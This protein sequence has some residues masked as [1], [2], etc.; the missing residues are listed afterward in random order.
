MDQESPTQIKS[1]GSGIYGQTFLGKIT[2]QNTE[3]DCTIKVPTTAEGAQEALEREALVLTKISRREANY[4]LIRLIKVFRDPNKKIKSV[5]TEFIPGDD[6]TFWSGFSFTELD[7]IL[8]DLLV[9]LT[10]IHSMDV[11][12]RDIKPAN[13]MYNQKEAVL[14]DFGSSSFGTV[15]SKSLKGSLRFL[16]KEL[17]YLADT[18]GI[19]PLHVLKRADVFALGFTVYMMAH[20]NKHPFEL[21]PGEGPQ[22][23]NFDT[24]TPSRYTFSGKSKQGH[25]VKEFNDIINRMLTKPTTAY[26][27]LKEWAPKRIP[28]MKSK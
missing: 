9:A 5:V 19:Y 2:I 7:R 11:V 4:N 17:I 15:P 12:H 10:V 21:M 16:S 8:T 1:L 18:I 28:K 14:I 20:K 27:L 13:V 25:T 24:F 3:I 22:H 26:D 6:L 23:S